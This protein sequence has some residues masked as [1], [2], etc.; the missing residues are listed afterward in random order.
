MR[1]TGKNNLPIKHEKTPDYI[2][3]ILLLHNQGTNEFW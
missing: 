2:F 1:G 3:S